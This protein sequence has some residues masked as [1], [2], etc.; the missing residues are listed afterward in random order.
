ERAICNLCGVVYSSNSKYGTGHIDR[1]LK[2]KHLA[3]IS[4]A[5]GD[6][7]LS[8][9]VYSKAN[10]RKGLALYVAAAKQ[11]FTFGDDI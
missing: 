10:M 2:T 7:D 6:S 5:N 3:E 8:N 9:F 1:H 4:E 11:P